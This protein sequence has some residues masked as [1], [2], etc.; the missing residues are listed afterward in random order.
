MLECGKCRKLRQRSRRVRGNV[1]REGSPDALQARPA[2]SKSHTVIMRVAVH[3]RLC[4]NEH[5]QVVKLRGPVRA[6]N[7]NKLAH[8][9]AL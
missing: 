5:L 4:G 2:T 6:W 9:A 3:L 8:S 1:Q 7:P